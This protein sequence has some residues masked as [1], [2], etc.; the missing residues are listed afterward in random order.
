MSVLA[1]GDAAGKLGM[2]EVDAGVDHRDPDAPPGR[3]R[4]VGGRSAE[5]VEPEAWLILG[6]L[7]EARRPRAD[8]AATAA[9]TAAALTPPRSAPASTAEP[10]APSGSPPLA[11]PARAT[12]VP[13]ATS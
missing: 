10:G 2:V 13:P 6:G 3:A 9:T 5:H 8:A 12:M 11:I 7:E 1:R 4:G